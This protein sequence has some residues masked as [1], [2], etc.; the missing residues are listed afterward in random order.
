MDIVLFNKLGGIF[1]FLFSL[2]KAIWHGPRIYRR[3]VFM[4]IA[5]PSPVI[6]AC[7]GPNERYIITNFLEWY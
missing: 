1:L 7:F 4:L 6:L 2:I 3:G 5:P